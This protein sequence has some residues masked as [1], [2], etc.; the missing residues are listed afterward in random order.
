MKPQTSFTSSPWWIMH[1]THDGDCFSVCLHFHRFGLCRFLIFLNFLEN[2]LPF[3]LLFLRPVLRVLPYV[4]V[5]YAYCHIGICWTGKVI[6]IML[7]WWYATKYSSALL[8]LV[9]MFDFCVEFP[10]KKTAHMCP[11]T[12]EKL[13][14]SMQWWV[15]VCTVLPPPPF[16]FLSLPPLKHWV[17]PTRRWDSVCTSACTCITI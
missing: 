1:S 10:L 3:F 7:R 5:V 17:S 16:L 8:F 12:H 11:V 13:C 6:T 15:C 2:T 9:C 14:L 4:W